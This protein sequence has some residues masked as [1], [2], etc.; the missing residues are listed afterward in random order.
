MAEIDVGRMFIRLGLELEEFSNG[1][2]QVEQ[3]LEKR[4]M[5]FGKLG[6]GLSAALTAPLAGLASEGLSTLASFEKEMNKVSAVGGIFGEDLK[7]L[8]AQAMML[9][10][11]TVYSSKQA[12]AA[13]GELAA[14]G[15]KS[16]EVYSAMPG[17]LSLAAVEGMK[18]GDAAKIAAA[19][20]NQFG[21][22][23]K[24]MGM[25]ADTMAATSSASAT[26]VQA[27]G[28]SFQYIGS[29]S[30]TTNQSFKDISAAL[31]A[32]AQ[33]GRTGESAGTALRSML[34]S[35][36]DPSKR[37]TAA[38]KAL[39]ES[40]Y[41]ANGQLKPMGELIRIL[42]PLMDD[43]QKGIAIFGKRWSDVSALLQDGGKNFYAISKGLEDVTGSSKKAADIMQQGLAG[44]FEK[45]TS[46]LEGVNLRIGKILAPIAME[47]M[48]MATAVSDAVSKSLDE[49]VKLDPMIQNAV[50]GFAA[51]LA[52][53]G[54][55]SLA[56]AGFYAALAT[57]ATTLPAVTAMFGAGGAGLAA[58]AT[59]GTA[60][61]VALAGWELYKI[62]KDLVELKDS[63]QALT[64]E[65]VNWSKSLEIAT[66]IAEGL[67]KILLELPPGFVPFISILK[68]AG[69]ET[70]GFVNFIRTLY[71][72]LKKLASDIGN[73]VGAIVKTLL[74]LSESMRKAFGDGGA[75][76]AKAM[77]DGAN[78]V[79]RNMMMNSETVAKGLEAMTIRVKE[80]IKKEKANVDDRGKLLDE[81][82]K[83]TKK[84]KKIVD[85]EMVTIKAALAS[86]EAMAKVDAAIID[87]QVRAHK[88]LSTDV[89][90]A[91][92][93]VILDWE[94]LHAMIGDT[95]AWK[96]LTPVME[97]VMKGIAKPLED[98][99]AHTKA[100]DDAFKNLGVKS[101]ESLR[102]VRDQAIESQ[103]AIQAAM[104][105]GE[106][107]T[108]QAVILAGQERILKA[109]KDLA[110]A[111]GQNF[112][113]YDE[114]L[115]NVGETLDQM[116]GKP[117]KMALEF[118]AF[119]KAIGEAFGNLSDN[120]FDAIVSG[121]GFKKAFDGFIDDLSASIR[122]FAKN[123]L[124]GVL[125]DAIKGNITSMNDLG[126]SATKAFKDVQ[127]VF[128][129]DVPGSGATGGGG[130]LG[131]S[132]KTSQMAAGGLTGWITAI[133]SAVS[134]VADIL[135]YLQGRRME[136][137]IGRMEVTTREI[138]AEIQ[139]LRADEWTREKHLF[140]LDRM[141]DA[142]DR[143]G[144]AHG[145]YLSD[146]LG[147]LQEIVLL[148][149]SGA[150]NGGGSGISPTWIDFGGS[151]G[152]SAVERL[153]ELADQTHMANYYLKEM[154]AQA[155]VSG[156]SL[157]DLSYAT[158]TATVELAEVSE[159]VA[160]T[161]KELKAG[162]KEYEEWKNKL[163]DTQDYDRWYQARLDAE[164]RALR[165]TD[166]WGNVLDEAGNTILLSM[167]F[168]NSSREQAKA[169]DMKFS[170]AIG[171]AADQIV[172][173]SEAA[174]AALRKTAEAANSASSGF[175]SYSRTLLSD[176]ND[177]A[178]TLGSQVGSVGG[179][180]PAGSNPGGSARSNAIWYNGRWVDPKTY[181][182][183]DMGSGA[184][185][186]NLNVTVNNA[187]AGKVA[188]T[189]MST[190]RAGGVNI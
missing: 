126:K 61:G 164:K 100:L 117:T 170:G 82:D 97:E 4:A 67:W 118:E 129:G 49:F 96:K 130:G 174:A 139:N 74:Q 154:E 26:S 127:K 20:I 27:L 143:F 105:T 176:I 45:L 184:G 13:M 6:I 21:F 32:L 135:M 12:A 24:D 147:H 113:V 34:M 36:Q 99:V 136:K 114:Q 110:I 151:G 128:T 7:K 72:G 188:N 65:F 88:Q 125:Q 53:L 10:D 28:N 145:A 9:G 64:S 121:E 16:N 138:K 75:E 156:S 123:I 93:K 33:A 37:G 158:D 141:A 55:V 131:D 43:A 77:A 84:K 134:A 89:H 163:K 83:Q 81:E 186:L 98:A 22:E 160:E 79:M 1:L 109:E 122:T 30:R 86:K 69:M 137:D 146:M 70:G 189:M 58:M 31:G 73:P 2:Q 66:I 175:A 120:L 152:G 179:G 167:D 142:T 18:I 78:S 112:E 39:K 5:A 91:L 187:D 153:Q 90:D 44:A 148:L 106:I 111:M 190:W 62:Y 168:I 181:L 159:T 38:L 59:A 71:E 29:V 68:V 104:D 102:A 166:R 133:S 41:E 108:S 17:V 51:L 50:L 107:E 15:F 132:A 56:I 162:T 92:R 180:S 87:F 182:P 183:V 173:G 80:V 48:K 19:A 46:S 124:K 144:D 169:T 95:S 35:L 101:V 60:V 171:Y 178:N 119:G 25:I 157:S 57:L 52:A 42:Q 8:T 149:Q 94:A 23:A 140:N 14:A 76:N 54:P 161:N 40:V 103:R 172:F 3:E 185:G 85:E 165:S 115:K 177:T 155:Q 47:L 150:F 11:T 116:S 63:V